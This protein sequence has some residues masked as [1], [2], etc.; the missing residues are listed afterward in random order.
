MKILCIYMGLLRTISCS[1]LVGLDKLITEHCAV[2]VLLFTVLCTVCT[3]VCTAHCTVCAMVFTLQWTVCTSVC[4]THCTVCA[5]VFTLQC[6]VCTSVCTTHCTVC[7]M[8]FTL[9]CTECTLYKYDIPV[10]IPWWNVSRG[11]MVFPREIF[12]QGSPTSV[13]Y[14]FYYTEHTSIW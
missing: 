14:L 7:A 1:T 3:S 6:T 9:Q 10:G 13:S 11:R 2:C 12:H 4:T 8:V 5:M